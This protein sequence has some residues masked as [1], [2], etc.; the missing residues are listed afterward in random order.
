MQQTGRIV[1]APTSALAARFA[2]AFPAN[3]FW[4]HD[5]VFPPLGFF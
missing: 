4:Q 3:C 5:W 1:K 2:Y